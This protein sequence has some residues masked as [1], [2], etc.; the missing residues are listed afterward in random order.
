[1]P[2]KI[3][4]GLSRKIGEPN[5]SSRGGSVHFEAEVEATLVRAA[6]KIA[7]PHPLSG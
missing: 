3:N 7:Q 1:M 6:K 4:V 2:L 5:Y